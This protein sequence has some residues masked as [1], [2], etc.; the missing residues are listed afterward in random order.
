MVGPYYTVAFGVMLGIIAIVILV[1]TCAI[2]L[3]DSQS[4]CCCYTYCIIAFSMAL[5][6]IGLGVA[7]FKVPPVVLGDNCVS[8]SYFEDIQMLAE[9]SR[10]SI[11]FSCACYFPTSV[12]QQTYTTARKDLLIQK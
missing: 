1:A 11:C 2:C 12:I 10:N 6:F 3:S 5:V 8:N 7:A 4:Y 9:V